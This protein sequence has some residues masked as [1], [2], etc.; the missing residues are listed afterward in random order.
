MKPELEQKTSGQE[1]RQS[2]SFT[3]GIYTL[4]D[5]AYYLASDGFFHPAYRT[6]E[7]EWL[8]SVSERYRLEGE[9]SQED[10]IG[11]IVK[12]SGF[13]LNNPRG[14]FLALAG[15]ALGV[16][17]VGTLAWVLNKR[18]SQIKEISAKEVLQL[19][20]KVPEQKQEAA[21][22]EPA[23]VVQEIPVMWQQDPIEANHPMNNL[24]AVTIAGYGCLLTSL[25]M[26]LRG[27][28]RKIDGQDPTPGIIDEQLTA[29]GGYNPNYPNGAYYDRQKGNET[30]ELQQKWQSDS[31]PDSVPPE[32][33][34]QVRGFIQDGNPVLAD[35]SFNECTYSQ[36]DDKYHGSYLQHFAPVVGWYKEGDTYYYLFNDPWTGIQRTMLEAEFQCKAYKFY[37][38]EGTI[39]MGG[40]IEE[41]IIKTGDFPPEIQKWWSLIGKYS[42][43]NS[44][45]P[46]LIASMML[47]E[48]GGNSL[49]YS[50][51]GAVGL[52]QIM[53][54]DGIS[55]DLYG[56]LFASR[57]TTEELKNPDFNMEYGTN[58][59][60]GLIK[61]FDGN[62][63]EALKAYGPRP[64]SMSYP[65]YY[66]DIIL[67]IW[68]RYSPEDFPK[69]YLEYIK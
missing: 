23:S 50:H 40:R 54:R 51:S 49:A 24:P 48:S 34:S 6:R 28:G 55:R 1:D 26:I 19:S 31:Y 3:P 62:I 41:N 35:I 22:P 17:G 68:N 67:K 10:F 7:D 38:Y 33:L 21:P 57:P 30:L 42:Q 2:L 15:T 20:P 43:K 27:L 39:A 61:R 14:R 32:V 16:A 37:V 29:K 53:P 66:A 4:G 63:R 8:Y 64:D 60:T 44:L 47:Q 45:S 58:M 56:D 18:F 65:Y 69:E 59:F 5:K 9:K 11:E 12:R 25:A 36:E 13:L 52:M 46:N